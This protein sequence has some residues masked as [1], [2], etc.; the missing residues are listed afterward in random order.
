[1]RK[2]LKKASEFISR[3]KEMLDKVSSSNT[4]PRNI[5]DKAERMSDDLN[6]KIEEL[7]RMREY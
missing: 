1:M 2:Q 7:E 5:R 3:A 6:E 4:I